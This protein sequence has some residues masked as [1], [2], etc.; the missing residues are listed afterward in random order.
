MAMKKLNS[1]HVSKIEER[2]WNGTKDG[3]RSGTNL[4]GEDSGRR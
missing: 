4:S 3:W 2:F 1:S